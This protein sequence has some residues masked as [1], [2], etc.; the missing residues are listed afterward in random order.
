MHSKYSHESTTLK[1]AIER[2]RTGISILRA[3]NIETERVLEIASSIRGLSRPLFHL[4]YVWLYSTAMTKVLASNEEKGRF[5][6]NV[7]AL[8]ALCRPIQEAFISLYY[9]AVEQIDEEESAFRDLLWNRHT[10]FKRFDLLKRYATLNALAAAELPEAEKAF[11]LIDTKLRSHSHWSTLDKASESR[12][13]NPE[14]YIS[15]STNQIWS[16]AGL[17]E[18]M[19]DAVFRLL[20]QFSHVTPYAMASLLGHQ[21]DTEEGAENMNVPINLALMC[22]C[23]SLSLIGSKSD[24]FDALLDPSFKKF[25]QSW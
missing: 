13:K 25:M 2:L 20:S 7:P 21:A 10:A 22:L 11:H 14:N 18:E 15:K 6:W 23:R 9:F 19:Y 3:A 12:L 4:K 16:H 5:L 24:E 17:P 8:A 1:S